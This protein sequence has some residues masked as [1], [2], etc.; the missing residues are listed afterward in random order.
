[1][2]PFKPEELRQRARDL[3]AAS[4]TTVNAERRTSLVRLA[5]YYEE[6]AVKLDSLT[7]PPGRRES[8]P[9]TKH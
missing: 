6:L 3:M 5:A 7:R 1:M 4:M 8:A 9:D 2:D